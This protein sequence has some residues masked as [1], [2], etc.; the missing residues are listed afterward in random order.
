MSSPDQSWISLR[1]FVM[2]GMNS[3]S[4]KNVRSDVFVVISFC[5]FFL[6]PSG[7]MQQYLRQMIKDNPSFLARIMCT[8]TNG[9]IFLLRQEEFWWKS[10]AVRWYIT[11]CH[12]A[13][14]GT[15]C[16]GQVKERV[17][18]FGKYDSSLSCSVHIDCKIKS[19]CSHH[20]ATDLWA[21]LLNHKLA[22]S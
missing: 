22:L 6:I 10:S 19:G 1:V 9:P 8:W 4:F 14:H 3:I 7:I 12:W 15:W 13:R 5:L 20:D 16:T 21:C 17:M 18:R 11:F 2:N